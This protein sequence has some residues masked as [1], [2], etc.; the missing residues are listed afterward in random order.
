MYSHLIKDADLQHEDTRPDYQAR[1][2]IELEVMA[3]WATCQRGRVAS[4][5]VDQR[6]VILVPARNGTP[7]G[8]PTCKELGAD[9]NVRCPYCRHSEK[10]VINFAARFGVRT[11][12]QYLYTLKRPCIDCASD[13]IQAGISFVYYREDYDSDGKRD[14]VIDMLT[15]SYVGI[16]QM[17]TTK[18]ER[19]FSKMLAEWRQTWTNN[20]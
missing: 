2:F 1:V 11:E 13:I 12:G 7:I 8:R 3:Q 19:S 5:L 15:S 6:G 18:Q 17:R 10:N 14:Y 16:F 4:A 20:A 9:P